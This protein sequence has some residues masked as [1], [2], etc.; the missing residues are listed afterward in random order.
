[1]NDDVLDPF[2][3]PDEAASPSSDGA[4][5]PLGD[6][7]PS[8]LPREQDPATDGPGRKFCPRC[9]APWDPTRTDCLRCQELAAASVRKTKALRNGP[10][11]RV[12]LSLYFALLG[13]MIVFALIAMASD[14]NSSD[15]ATVTT[16]SLAGITV[17]WAIGTKRYV[18]P[19]I[20]VTSYWKWMI[21]G[22]SIGSG[23]FVV[24]TM[25]LRAL[26]AWTGIEKGTYLDTFTDSGGWPMA[27]LIVCVF[28]GI[29]E[30]LAFRGVIF[31]SMRSA[32]GLREVIVVSGLMFMI[33]HLSPL[34]F[35][36]LAVIGISLGIVRHRSG[37]LYPCMVAHFTHNFLCVLEEMRSMA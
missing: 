1:M 27:V 37:S 2:Q 3:P 8:Q 26:I 4:R 10:R 33:L 30:E 36:H 25:F 15:F 20:R 24:A 17:L 6:S 5:A 23:T 34:S 22:V 13:F 28:P 11:L 32:L 14:I 31:E 12:G 35:P 7:L 21:F 29:F 19:V 16:F 18:L 9:G